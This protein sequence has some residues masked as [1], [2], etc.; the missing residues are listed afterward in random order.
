LEKKMNP[1]VSTTEQKPTEFRADENLFITQQWESYTA[2]DHRCWSALFNKR[3]LHLESV[4]SERY[5]NGISAIGM[6][7]DRIPLLADVNRRLAPLTGWSAI[8]VSGFLKPRDFFA[9]LAQRRFPTTVSIRSLHRMDY[10]PE[11]DI[12][13]D[14]FGHVPLH[15]DP[16]FADYLQRFGSLAARAEDDAALEMVG[17]LFWFTVEFGLIRE[18]GEV[19]VYGSGLISSQADSINALGDACDRR[20]FSLEGVLAQKFSTSEIQPV[21]F[22]IES[23]EQLFEEVRKMEEWLPPRD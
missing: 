17:R 3:M 1:A 19:R 9:C 11:P 22:V 10:V 2:E 14:V 8:P 12:F 15:A 6:E 5:L 23:F 4:A 13:H 18:H 16:V 7:P 21:L 20:P